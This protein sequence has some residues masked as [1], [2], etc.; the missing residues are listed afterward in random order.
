MDLVK[1]FLPNISVELNSDS[2]RHLFH[3]L[4][5]ANDIAHKDWI[6]YQEYAIADHYVRDKEMIEESLCILEDID[7]EMDRLQSLKVERALDR[8]LDLIVRDHREAIAAYS[9]AYASLKS[10]KFDV[11]F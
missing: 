6:R 2:K 11:P 5:K 9:E 8:A 4:S 3:I 1:T 10:G 7:D